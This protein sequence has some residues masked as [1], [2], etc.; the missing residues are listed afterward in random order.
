MKMTASLSLYSISA[1][2]QVKAGSDY[3]E[4]MRHI[5]IPPRDPATVTLETWEP[6][7]LGELLCQI[8]NYGWE[9]TA[10]E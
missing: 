9:N 10:E 5:R 2:Q 7:H 3:G 6:G 8:T 4:L 1:L